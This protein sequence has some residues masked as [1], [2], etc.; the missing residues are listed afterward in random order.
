M[1][2][3]YLKYIWSKMKNIYEYYINKKIFILATYSY[4]NYY[5]NKLLDPTQLCDVL[6]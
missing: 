1:I 4:H 2:V 3:I 5:N 6:K